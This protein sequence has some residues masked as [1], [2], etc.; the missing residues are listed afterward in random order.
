MCAAGEVVVRQGW[1]CRQMC[2]LQ[3][4]LLAV[5]IDGVLVEVLKPG[6]QAGEEALLTM[7]SEGLLQQV[8]RTR[9]LLGV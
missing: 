9:W 5:H 4:G 8:C 3:Q 2:V 6:D 7:P 1:P